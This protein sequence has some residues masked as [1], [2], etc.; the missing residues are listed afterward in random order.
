MEYFTTTSNVSRRAVD[1]V[2]V[3]VYERGRLAAGA[4]QIDSASKGA[5][6]RHLKNGDVSG[7][8]GHCTVVTDVAGV[9]AKRVAVVGLGKISAFDVR[10]FSQAFAAA[11][12]S[13]SRSKSRQI[14]NTLTLEKTSGAG[15]Y[16]L[17]RHTA[18]TIGDALYRFTEMKSGKKAPVMPLKKVGMSVASRGEASKALRGA[19]H[20][21][22]IV[23]G[24]NVAKD[25]GNLPA[26][27]CTPSYIARTAKKIAS[28]NGNLQTR[29]LNEAEMKRLGM[30]SLLSAPRSLQN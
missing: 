24:M 12:R 15:S 20:G 16:Y 22:A 17:G 9:R 7:Q 25:L 19:T 27:V 3:G 11:L 18:Q 26:N 13:I 21:D 5:L 23:S 29:V 6:K 2:I 1:C 28:G 4:N 14:L 10:K 30:H 8:F